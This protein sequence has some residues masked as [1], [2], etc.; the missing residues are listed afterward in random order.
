M[1][2][3][4]HECPNNKDRNAN[5]MSSTSESNN[6]LTEEARSKLLELQAKLQEH[7]HSIEGS[8][9]YIKFKQGYDSKILNIEPERTKPENVSYNGNQN[10]VLQY[11]FYARELIDKKTQKWTKVREWTVS[12]RWANLVVSLLLKGFLTLE[13][14]RRGSGI[15]D[16]SYS[17]TPFVE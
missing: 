7:I 12:P 6:K 13:V 15:N 5:E 14:T 1:Q 8:S 2:A 9:D 16:T 10:P 4:N 3:S 17:V 11:K